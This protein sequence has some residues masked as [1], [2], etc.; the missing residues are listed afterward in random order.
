MGNQVEPDCTPTHSNLYCRNLPD[1][2]DDCPASTSISSYFA[3]YGAVVSCRV[4]ELPAGGSYA[5]VKMSTVEEAHRAMQEINAGS[6]GMEVKFA[7]ADAGPPLTGTGSTPSNNLYL[8]NLPGS[9]SEEELRSQLV[10]LLSPFGSILECRVLHAG[11][12]LRGAGALVRLSSVEEASRAIEALNNQA[13]GGE[14][15]PPLLVR[16]ADTPEEKARKLVKRERAFY[17]SGRQLFTD[18]PQSSGGVSVSALPTSLIAGFTSFNASGLPETSPLQ[19]RPHQLHP[20]ALQ[21]QQQLRVA[22][23]YPQQQP[24]HAQQRQQGQHHQ[25]PPHA[26]P[27]ASPETPH[28]GSRRRRERA[29]APGS[30]NGHSVSPSGGPAS[31]EG[32]GMS[33]HG[34]GYLNGYS[35]GRGSAGNG[36][37]PYSNGN[38]QMHSNGGSQHYQEPQ[39]QAYGYQV[40]SPGPQYMT[41]YTSVYIKNLPES[42]NKLFLYE[43]FAPYGA[44]L[45][46]KVLLDDTSSKCRGVGF[47]NFADGNAA[48]HAIQAVNGSKAG[49]KMLH[50]SLQT[51]RGRIGPAGPVT[52]SRC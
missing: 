47:V 12:T 4:V 31:H 48:L 23:P 26:S 15:G 42:A 39:G 32:N 6:S 51:Q 10:N 8:R 27:A 40:A 49:E 1:L 37:A 5:F 25:Q 46:V 33:R 29:A 38:Q 17:T 13:L 44:V 2:P 34:S 30:T 16:Y 9:C 41:P 45:S 3:P 20:H 50:V 24:Q 36:E 21:Q 52:P 22:S 14:G 7:D 19:R 28:N 18:R 11:D 35:N 43:R